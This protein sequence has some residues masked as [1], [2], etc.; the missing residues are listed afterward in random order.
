VGDFAGWFSGMIET[1]KESVSFVHYL[2]GSEREVKDDMSSG[3]KIVERIGNVTAKAAG[4][5]ASLTK[6]YKAAV[7]IGMQ[8]KDAGQTTT[9]AVSALAP[10]EMIPIVGIVT[11][12]IG[13]IQ[14]AYKLWRI[15]VRRSKLTKKIS[16]AT[17]ESA[18]DDVESL[19][20]AHGSLVKRTVRLGKN[21]AH[22]IIS[23]V[24]SALT[25]GGV[26]AP[27]TLAIG[28][29]QTAEK[30]GAVAFRKAKQYSR[31][32][33][34]QHRAL[35]DEKRGKPET[36]QEWKMRKRLQAAQKGKGKQFV[37][38]L[39][40]FF[41]RNWDKSSVGK[42]Q[43]T[44]DAAL[45]ILDMNDNDVFDALGITKEVRQSGKSYK[46]KLDMVIK[47]LNKRD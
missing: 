47:A 36:F 15:G 5:G 37:T 28:I 42:A 34:A 14:N 1:I 27:A 8:I 32:K 9:E 3:R 45:H 21:L 44:R 16:D 46:E 7:E 20:F 23:I 25:L 39:D 38:A 18:L 40:V 35:K 43:A 2:D 10:K 26:T 22:S 12:S 24:S 29:A 17:V 30:L 6:T 19:E 41:T 31:D 4:I 13:A 33:K 11:G